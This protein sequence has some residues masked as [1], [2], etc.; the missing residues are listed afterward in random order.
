MDPSDSLEPGIGSLE[1]FGFGSVGCEWV[2]HYW[3]LNS[4]PIGPANKMSSKRPWHS[5]LYL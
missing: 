1:E 4:S 3:C 5:Y 2:N